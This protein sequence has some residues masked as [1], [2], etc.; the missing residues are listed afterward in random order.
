MNPLDIVDIIIIV[1]CITYVFE[2][3]IKFTC[4]YARIQDYDQDHRK[5]KIILLK[6]ICISLMMSGM[7]VFDISRYVILVF[8]MFDIKKIIKF[9]Q[10]NWNVLQNFPT[11][12][13]IE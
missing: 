7:K 8:M 3:C 4:K 1:K 6:I 12:M 10:K 9:T 11:C 2:M 13:N 5:K